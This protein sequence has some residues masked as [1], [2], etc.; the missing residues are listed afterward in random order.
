MKTDEMMY[1]LPPE[2]FAREP[3]ELHGGDRGASKLLVMNRV[4]QK[5]EHSMFPEI[6]DYLDTG[7]LIILN[8]T[9]TIKAQLFGWA[10]E[11]KRVDVR[12]CVEKGDNM[13]QCLI[14][15]SQS[16]EPGSN[17]RFGNGKLTGTVI[18][19]RKEL[20][21]WVVKF[22]VENRDILLK[23]L[24]EI[25]VPI[26][27]PYAKKRISIDHL[28]NVYAKIEGSAEM[29]TA[30][31]HFTKELMKKLEKQGIKFAYVTLHTGLSS[32]AIGEA[33]FEE[34]TMYEE[35]YSISQ[36]T[37]DTINE[38]RENGSQIVGCGTTTVRV[39][40]TVADNGG[41]VKPGGGYTDLYIYPGY[42]WKIIDVLITNFHPWRT[43]RI[44]LAA[45]FTGKDLL[46]EGYNQAIER[47]YMFY[48]YGDS[49]LTL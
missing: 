34:H 3:R 20:P 2:L 25:A 8:N 49:T 14:L 38:T 6:G 24:D 13:W 12:L 19:K 31:R 46:M 47:G 26:V 33:T 45:A 39:L 44:A 21:L 27:P 41:N 32:I 22:D 48:D 23:I 37:A 40:E 15:P 29:P 16:V 43:S 35:K 42:T 7:D 36:E 4:T 30:G 9:K 10:D 1:E 17:L 18:E 5:V 28:Q 11:K